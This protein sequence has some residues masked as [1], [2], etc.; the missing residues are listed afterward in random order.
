MSELIP[1]NIVIGDRT[2]RIKTLA[3]DE[4][5]IRRTLKTVNDKIIEFKTQF[6]G[7]DM[8][9]YIAMVMIWYATLA[10]TDSNPVLEKEVTDALLKMEL[11]IDKA[12]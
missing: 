10:N 2:Y 11:A 4:E 6:G 8:Q 9:D 5:V 7:K 1:I 12:L 3:K